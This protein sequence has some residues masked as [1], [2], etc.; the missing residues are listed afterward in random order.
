MRMK[1]KVTAFL[2]G[3]EDYRKVSDLRLITL[4]PASGRTPL[5]A[6]RCSGQGMDNKVSERMSTDGASMAD[7]TE[8]RVSDLIEAV[9]INNKLSNDSQSLTC[10]PSA[11]R[12]F[13]NVGTLIHGVNSTGEDTVFKDCIVLDGSLAGKHFYDR[14]SDYLKCD[15]VPWGDLIHVQR[16]SVT[17]TESLP[18]A[19]LPS[20]TAVCK[21]IKDE[22]EPSVIMGTPTPSPNFDASA[23]IPVLDSSFTP[24]TVGPRPG[25]EQGSPN[26]LIDLN[27]PEQLPAP[28]QGRSD[29]RCSLPG[30]AGMQFDANTN[31]STQLT[32][33]KSEV[34]RWQMQASPPEPQYWCQSAAFAEEPSTRGSYDGIQSQALIQRNASPYSTFPG[35][36]PQRM[37]M[38]CGDEASGCHYGVLTCGSCKVFFKR[39]V[40]GHHSYLCAGRNDCIVDKIRRK[41]CPACRLRKCYQA[42]M[43]L[44]GRKLKRF[45]ALKALGLPPSLMYQSHLAVSSDNQALTSMSCMPGIR[46]VHL[47]QHILNVLENIEPEVMYSGYDNSQTDVPHLLL[48]SLNRLCEKQLLWIVKWSKSL[49]GFRNLHI[50]D[51]MTLI[52]Y[53]WMNLMVFSLGWRSFQ[54]VTSEYLYF[55]PDLVLSQEQMRRSPIYDLCLAIQFIPQEFANLQ[56]TREEF[57]CMKAIILLNT[58]P[59]EGLKSQAAFEEMRQSYVRELTKAIHMREKGLVASSQRFY[60]LTKLM[61]AMHDIVKKVNLFCLSTF[62]QADAMRVEFPEMMSEVIASQLPKVLAGMVR[63]LLFHS[64]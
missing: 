23:E 35:M 22:Q 15:S 43:M 31:T 3:E 20:T 56:V 2:N 7:F 6:V 29:S 36:P 52:Q 18:Y 21:F 64:K 32:T 41:N 62:I 1:V 25:L 40:E 63:P 5:S 33:F 60:H 24:G 61:D 38:I 8:T 17:T 13:G 42:G 48:N 58:V 30:K 11:V 39:A 47:S 34:P 59:L 19:S 16:T 57:L 54:N 55:A 51:Q 49:P 46:E 27:Q 4:R 26:F 9:Y 50:N 12:N 44:G 14:S 10:V 37:C 53:S 45:G 28:G